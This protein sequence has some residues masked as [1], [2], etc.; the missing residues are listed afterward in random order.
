[1]WRKNRD[2]LAAFLRERKAS[3]VDRMISTWNCMMSDWLQAAMP[4]LGHNLLKH[5]TRTQVVPPLAK[6]LETEAAIHLT[7]DAP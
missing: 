3:S 6:S 4:S 1:M 5:R 2:S 7:L